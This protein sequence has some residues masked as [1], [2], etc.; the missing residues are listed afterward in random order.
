MPNERLDR[1]EFIAAA[2][3]AALAA[4]AAK[5]Q[6]QPGPD[7]TFMNATELVRLLRAR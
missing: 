2:G 5:A 6:A 4:G 7:L 3:A 1:R